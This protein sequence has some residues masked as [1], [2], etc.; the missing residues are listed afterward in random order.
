MQWLTKLMY[1]RYGTD[2]LGFFML[3]LVLILDVIFTFTGWDILYLFSFLLAVW[4]I[5]RIFSRNI[6][7]RYAENQKFMQVFSPVQNMIVSKI[8]GARDLKTHRHFRCPSC[9][10]KIRVPRGRGKIQITC[11]KCGQEFIKKS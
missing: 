9:K 3:I 2:V 1:G 11:P 8:S 6:S 7:R 5:W 10:Q 4:C